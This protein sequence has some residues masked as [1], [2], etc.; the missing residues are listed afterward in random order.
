M[1]SGRDENQFIQLQEVLHG[2]LLTISPDSLWWS[3][4]MNGVFS[5]SVA[6]K[7][8]EN[9]T[10]IGTGDVTRWC[11]VVPK[12]VNIFMWRLFLDRL[13]TRLNLSRKGLELDSIT[14]LLCAIGVESIQHVFFSSLQS[15]CCSVGANCEIV[16]GG[17]SYFHL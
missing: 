9:A 1:R 8:I 11:K 15:G 4:D 16:W 14:C 7:H 17:V 6:R 2:I 3:L 5:V 12:K 10:Y 13:P